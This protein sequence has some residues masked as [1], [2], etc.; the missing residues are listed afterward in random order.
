MDVIGFERLVSDFKALGLK[1]GDLINVKMSLKSIGRVEGG[2]RTVLDAILDVVGEEG[3][4]VTD[5]F[6]QAYRL[7]L[8]S[9]DRKV[10]VD[11]KTPSYAGALA[12]AIL[13][14]PNVVRSKHPI[15]KFAAVGKL[16]E[17]LMLKHTPESYA[18]DVLRR[19]CGLGG[20]NLK[21]GTDEVVV[22]VGTTH[23][24]I[25][26]MGFK[27]RR[28]P[29]GVLY[30][31]DVGEVRLF[32]LNWSGI[33]SEGL[34]NFIPYYR[35]AGAILSEGMIGNSEA[36]ITDMAGTLKVELEL[37]RKDPKF[38]FCTDPTCDGCQLTWSFSGKKYLKF[39]RACLSRG[40]MKRLARAL[41]IDP[42]SG[43]LDKLSVLSRKSKG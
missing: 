6:V 32:R 30:R 36:K 13:Q 26:E 39:V 40:E 1:P 24:A 31:D 34:I 41:L 33:C 2:A 19:M 3:T 14:H 42:L 17:E 35:K 4:V 37:L 23:V 15:Q 9:A 28:P 12:N 16:A 29:V 7:P 18:Y 8:S 5:S 10:V 27:Q 22:G 20:K 38:F 25:G 43:A 11:D 21:I